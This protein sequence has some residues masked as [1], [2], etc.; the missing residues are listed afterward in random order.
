[1]SSGSRSSSPST[2]G[3]DLIPV[4]QTP[5]S[6]PAAPLPEL[7]EPALLSD[8]SS[9]CGYVYDERMQWH[10]GPVNFPE[11]GDRVAAVRAHLDKLGLLARCRLLP[12]AAAE[13]GDLLSCH[14][15]AY[16]ESVRGQST[17]YMQSDM[18]MGPSSDLAG[19]LSCGAVVGAARAVAQSVVDAAFAIV[20]PPGHHAEPC[21]AMGF[22]FFSN[23]AVAAWH[24]RR[25]LKVGR[26][27]IVDW[28]VHH[29]NGTQRCVEGLDDLLFVSIHRHEGG[30]FYPFSGAAED[31]GTPGKAKAWIVNVPW[32]RR[33]LGDAEYMDAFQRVVEPALRAFDPEIILVSAGYDAAEGDPLGRMCVSP[34]CF[35][36]MTAGLKAICPK[37]VLAMEGGYN[38]SAL[39]YA[40]EASL[41]VLMGEAPQPMDPAPGEPAKDAREVVDSVR[42]IHKDKLGL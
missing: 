42:A 1:M 37:L 10:T 15:L 27:A 8:P 32:P 12:F 20:R 4:A 17:E 34:E 41:R 24:L 11:R 36:A 7:R 33:G 28:D 18:Y 31:R 29:G 30:K 25:E 40:V 23:V 39:A 5:V 19:R 26:I 16:I 13:D 3:A 2:D 21:Q 22:C 35:A 14:E 6:L 9:R 38:R